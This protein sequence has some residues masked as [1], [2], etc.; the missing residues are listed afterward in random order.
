MNTEVVTA[1][2]QS[3]SR[4]M[5]CIENGFIDM[6]AFPDKIILARNKTNP[7]RSYLSSHPLMINDQGFLAIDGET[8]TPS[9]ARSIGHIFTVFEVPEFRSFTPFVIDI[10]NTIRNEV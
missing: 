2:N 8:I 6:N 10:T 9:I 1:F 5:Y 4:L 7:G 3:L